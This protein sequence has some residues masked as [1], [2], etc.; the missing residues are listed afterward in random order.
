MKSRVLITLVALSVWSCNRDGANRIDPRLETLYGER[1]L[2]G[3]PDAFTPISIVETS[4]PWALEYKMGLL[5][6]KRFDLY[7]A[8]TSFQRAEFLI[9]EDPQRSCYLHRKHEVQY[10]ILLC[11][12]LGKRYQDLIDTYER[13]SLAFIDRSFSAYRDLLVLLSEAYGKINQKEKQEKIYTLL[14]KIDQE[15]RRN[16]ELGEAIIQANFTRLGDFLHT[17]EVNH[18]FILKRYRKE[19]HLEEKLTLYKKHSKSPYVAQV[20]NGL[21]PGAGYYYLGQAQSAFT[22]F[23]L[24]ALFIGTAVYFF[25]QKNIPAAV[26]TLT[27]ES[28]WY[29]GGMYGA[30]EAAKLYN[31]RL[32]ER[33]M[34]PFLDEQKLFPLLQ[35]RYGF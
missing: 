23:S 24:N 8:I 17:E 21:L 6:A 29:F 25:N 4:K 28:G 30:R 11:Y 5:F 18:S 31:E 14:G 26:L 22:A 9:S 35:I 7:R 20:L 10:L 19:T 34:Q 2:F 13:S 3:L 16:L 15:T 1:T 33:E 12:S 32:Y 27:V